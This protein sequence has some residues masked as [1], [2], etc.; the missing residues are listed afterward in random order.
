MAESREQQSLPTADYS[1]ESAADADGFHVDPRLLC[2]AVAFGALGCIGGTQSTQAE[3]GEDNTHSIVYQPERGGD[4]AH[5]NAVVVKGNAIDVF[6]AVPE[7]YEG[8]QINATVAL[9]RNG[10]VVESGLRVVSPR[11]NPFSFAFD[12]A[13]EA[14]DAVEVALEGAP[15]FVVTVDGNASGRGA[16][17]R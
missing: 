6:M 10:N 13:I 2:V 8:E 7:G 11:E 12:A 17:P 5:V 15:T 4:F 1:G 3:R 14:G 16:M 9:L